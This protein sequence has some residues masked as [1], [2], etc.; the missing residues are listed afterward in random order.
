MVCREAGGSVKY[1]KEEAYKLLQ[2]EFPNTD[3]K[4]TEIIDMSDYEYPLLKKV[5][6]TTGAFRDIYLKTKN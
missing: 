4:Y 2:L 6:Y 3:E 1:K 5:D